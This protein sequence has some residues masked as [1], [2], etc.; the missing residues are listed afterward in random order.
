M[1]SIIDIYT[2][3]KA[4]VC[5]LISFLLLQITISVKAFNLRKINDVENLSS[6]NIFSIHQDGKGLIWIGTGRGVDVY[7]GKQVTLYNP[8]CA[9]NFFTGCRI[10]K[11]E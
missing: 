4:I 7:D 8:T 3:K 5:F 2:G 9:E 1:I 10:D 11:I 6:S